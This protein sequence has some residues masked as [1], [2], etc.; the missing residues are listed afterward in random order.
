MPTRNVNSTPSQTGQFD[1]S[2]VLPISELHPR[3]TRCFVRVLTNRIAFL[4]IFRTVVGSLATLSCRNRAALRRRS[5]LQC[6]TTLHRMGSSKIAG[7]GCPSNTT[8]IFTVSGM[9]LSSTLPNNRHGRRSSSK[10]LSLSGSMKAK[11]V[12]SLEES[13]VR[14]SSLTNSPSGVLMETAV[15]CSILLS[16]LSCWPSA[17]FRRYGVLALSI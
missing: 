16:A 2:T 10:P 15:T 1:P 9:N 8:S 14:C 7:F 5:L 3:P 12:L 4:P 11:T 17:I 6:R 13:S